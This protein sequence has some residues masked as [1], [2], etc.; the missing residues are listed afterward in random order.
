MTALWDQ[1]TT[2][3]ALLAATQRAAIGKRLQP[4]V[5][6]FL[7]D[8][9]RLCV[10]LR[11]ALRQ[12]TWRP[13]PPRT[14]RILDPKPRTITV[15]PF[16]DRVVHHALCAV[17]EPFFERF[18]IEDSYACRRGK[19]QHAALARARHLCTQAPWVWKGDIAAFFASIPHDPLLA[20]IRRRLPC[21][22]LCNALESIVRAVPTT[23]DRGLPIG[24]LTS[25]HLANLYLGL[26][27]H[28]IKD[29]LGVRRYLRFMDDFLVFGT[30]EEVAHLR[31]VVA[32]FVRDRLDLALSAHGTRCI[33]VRDGVPWLGWR[34]YPR[35]L[36]LRPER[37]RAFRREDRRVAKALAA[38]T[39]TEEEAAASQTSRY[40]HLQVVGSRPFHKISLVRVLG[41]P[42]VGAG[43]SRSQARE[44]RRL[45]QEL[46]AERPG[47]EPQQELAA[48]RR[49]QP[50]V[51]RGEHNTPARWFG[52]GPD[53]LG[54]RIQPPCQGVDQARV[55]RV[56]GGLFSGGTE[57]PRSG[58]GLHR[59]V[60]AGPPPSPLRRGHD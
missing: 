53:E 8:R 35:L 23:P 40:A 48:E 31:A 34:V 39:L 60:V 9:E 22:A 51:S 5:A 32:A 56:L 46:G 11:D 37:L 2:V 26:L 1:A 49:R 30:S 57:S 28:F 15:L 16:V 33:P 42:G 36:R 13:G 7:M 14:F 10:R 45:L 43:R 4:D 38:G 3:S 19:G 52:L 44:P 41:R 24:A 55:Q 54:L 21:S 20:L 25:Q 47:G 17:A 18:A 6:R 50:G 59:G 58:G 27:D 12:G 29:E